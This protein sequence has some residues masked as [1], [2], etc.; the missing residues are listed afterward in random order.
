M[1]WSPSPPSPPHT[2]S[3]KKK[4]QNLIS[5]FVCQTRPF[6]MFCQNRVNKQYQVICN[7]NITEWGKGKCW[8]NTALRA[9]NKFTCLIHATTQCCRATTPNCCATTQ[10]CRATT[11]SC[12]ATSRWL[13]KTTELA[14]AD[15][16]C[17]SRQ[18]RSKVQEPGLQKPRQTA[19]S[20][21][22]VILHKQ[23]T[24]WIHICFQKTCSTFL[25]VSFY[26]LLLLSLYFHIANSS[27]WNMQNRYSRLLVDT[28]LN[29]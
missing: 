4:K 6:D 7:G 21:A 27:Q 26:F 2:H 23:I 17:K 14:K 10:C 11:Q 28:S 9:W 5:H 19:H 20:W 25:L 29:S 1:I 16:E 18:S 3:L 24:L 8:H 22:A 12:H 13:A 15:Q